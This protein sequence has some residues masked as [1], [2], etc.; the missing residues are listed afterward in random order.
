ML[1]YVAE[2]QA[3]ADRSARL[4]ADLYQAITD[5]PNYGGPSDRVHKL[6]V[7][8]KAGWA[9]YDELCDQEASGTLIAIDVIETLARERTQARRKKRRTTPLAKVIGRSI[10]QRQEAVPVTAPGGDQA[11]QAS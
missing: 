8:L 10:P 2:L 7:M 3:A 1:D 5:L 4:E 9:L 11:A 6:E